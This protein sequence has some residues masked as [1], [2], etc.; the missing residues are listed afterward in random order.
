MLDPNSR[1]LLADAVRPPPGYRFATG[2]ALTYSLDL[3]TLL[4]IPVELAVLASGRRDELLKDPVALLEALRRTT[5]NLAVVCQRGRI[6]VPGVPH[7]LYGL[8]EPCVVEVNAP[9]GG[10]FHPKLWALRYETVDGDAGGEDGGGGRDGGDDGDVLTRLVVLSRNLTPDNSWDLSLVLEGRPQGRRVAENRPVGEL[11]AAVPGMATGPVSDRVRALLSGAADLI[12]RTRW[13]ELPGGFEELGFQVLGLQPKPWKVEPADKLA[14][15]S[16]FLTAAAIKMLADAADAPVALVSRPEEL[17]HIPAGVLRRFAQCLTLHDQAETDDG[18]DAPARGTLRGLHAKAYVA[19]RG[20]HTTLSLGSANA[21]TPSLLDGRNV[22]VLVELTGRRSKVGGV[23]RLL[24]PDGLGGCLVEFVPP[25][26]PPGETEQERAERLLEAARDVIGSLG[27]R[28][29]CEPVPRAA[30]GG[31][32]YTLTLRADRPAVPAAALDGVA[33]VRAWPVSMPGD[34][35]VDAAALLRGEAVA[36]GP[37]AAASLTGFV[38]FELASSLCDGV[39]ACFV[40]NLPVDGMPAARDAA[41]LRTIVANRD[42]FLRYLLMLL[43]DDGGGGIATDGLLAALG[44]GTG[45]WGKGGL[46][47]P[48][49]LEEMTRAFSRDPA[50]LASVKRMVDELLRAPGGA[51]IVPAEFLEVWRLYESA[52]EDGQAVDAGGG[53]G[54]QAVAP[55]DAAGRAG[56]GA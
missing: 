30:D 32:A 28:A 31:D 48:P 3:T 25:P 42:G 44:G 45:R 33:S 15:L 10:V 9:N 40:L 17:A 50:R 5:A 27:L 54:P 46:D 49:L 39:S 18:E 16:P 11:L 23:E 13:D 36:V 53:A 35:A 43:R 21:T 55:D 19:E 7:V 47:A 14:V 8:L 34:R 51:D 41:V 56:G 52:L 6:H 38:A 2:V 12:R 26:Q 29:A 20:W 37:L 4:T 22:E 1:S 24:G